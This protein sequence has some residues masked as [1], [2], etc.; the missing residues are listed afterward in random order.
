[1]A[2]YNYEQ[3]GST[4]KTDWQKLKVLAKTKTIGQLKL[5]KEFDAYEEGSDYIFFYY[6]KLRGMI[7]GIEDNAPYIARFMYTWNYTIEDWDELVLED[8]ILQP[9]DLEKAKEPKT[10][11]TQIV[12][13]DYVDNRIDIINANEDWSKTDSEEY[14]VNRGYNLDN[15][16]WIMS[17]NLKINFTI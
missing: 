15:I 13:M 16:H 14:L 6:K 9:Y 8:I 11:Y 10:E 12:V 17:P 3:I 1:M 7:Y 5:V 2:T 4:L